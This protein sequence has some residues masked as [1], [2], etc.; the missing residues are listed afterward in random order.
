MDEELAKC[1]VSFRQRDL[2][3]SGVLIVE[4]LQHQLAYLS[5]RSG[6]LSYFSV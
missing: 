6:L 1:D 4:F 3:K 5:I 2:K